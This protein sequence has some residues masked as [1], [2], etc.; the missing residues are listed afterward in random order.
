MGPLFGIDQIRKL[1]EMIIAGLISPNKKSLCVF[2]AKI[3]KML[4]FRIT[5]LKVNV[6]KSLMGYLTFNF[7]C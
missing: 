2:I 6:L 7:L 4:I 5:I 3:I 1:C